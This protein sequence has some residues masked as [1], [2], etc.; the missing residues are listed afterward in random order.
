M[1]FNFVANATA[2]TSLASSALE[3]GELAV[4]EAKQSAKTAVAIKDIRDF[5]GDSML[6]KSSEKHNAMKEIV[7]N[8][9]FTVGIHKAA[10]AITGFF[11]GFVEGMKGNLPATGF[12][13]ITLLSSNRTV[14][15][16][17]AVGTGVSMFFDFIKNGTNFF[18]DKSLIEK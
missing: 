6:N 10:G 15:A 14:K 1:A 2:I 5:T 9:D 13:L 7:R 17:G 16:I 3:A 8:S 11:G 4:R 12:S 18:V